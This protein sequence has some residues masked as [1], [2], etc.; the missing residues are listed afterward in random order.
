[1]SPLLITILIVVVVATLFGIGFINHTLETNK[2]EKARQKADLNDRLRR[3]SEVSES[4][5]GQL[6]TPALKLMLTRLLLQLSE[7]LL[8]VDKGNTAL[9]GRTQTMREEIAKGD[10]ITVGNIVQP[11][12]TEA[13]AKEVRFLLESL[14]GQLGRAVKDGFLQ[15]IEAKSW[16]KELRHMLVH[17]HVEFFTNLGQQMLLQKQPRQAR[18]SFER[19]VQYLRKQ[20]EPAFY[21]KQLKQLEAHLER[22]T[23]LVME[24]DAAQPADEDAPL[25]GGLKELEDEDDIWRKKNFYE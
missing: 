20:P 2:L 4:M 6:M 3:C 16:A 18:L 25:Q 1:M 9:Q 10:A 5:P 11:I 14:H 19:G 15:P 8:L 17:L 13:K 12:L 21:Q 24:E 7:R 22:A 23:A